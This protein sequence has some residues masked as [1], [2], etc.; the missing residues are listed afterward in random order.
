MMSHESYHDY[1][2]FTANL[3]GFQLIAFTK[4][5]HEKL[6]DLRQDLLETKQGRE[7]DMIYPPIKC[8]SFSVLVESNQLT[9]QFLLTN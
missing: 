9:L 1:D 5:R 2:L 7:L 8:G 3:F 4:K 6:S